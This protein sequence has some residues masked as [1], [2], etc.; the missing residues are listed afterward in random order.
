MGPNKM[1]DLSGIDVFNHVDNQIKMEY[2]Y[3]YDS[4]IL[5]ELVRLNRL[6]Q[7]TKRGLYI[8]DDKR[9]A[10]ED[11]DGLKEILWNIDNRKQFKLKFMKNEL[12]DEIL[13]I[14]VYYL[15]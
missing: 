9:N 7:K 8:Y 2:N 13:L 10:F 5:K 1:M 3:C 4:S 6:G 12:S 14:C 11:N 15:L